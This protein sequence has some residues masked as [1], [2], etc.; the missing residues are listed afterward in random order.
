VVA[1]SQVVAQH[2]NRL[3]FIEQTMTTVRS[4]VNA[5]TADSTYVK[6]FMFEQMSL[7]HNVGEARKGLARTADM[8]LPWDNYFQVFTI[9]VTLSCCD[10]IY[11]IMLS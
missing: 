3:D 7:Y 1:Y 2:S 10:S 11:S 9:Y 8:F 5:A 6:Q 4:E